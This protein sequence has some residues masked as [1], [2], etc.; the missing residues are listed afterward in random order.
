MQPNE[1]QRH[2]PACH[3][4]GRSSA[5]RCG[6]RSCSRG[7]GHVGH[8]QLH[9]PALV[10][11]HQAGSRTGRDGPATARQDTVPVLYF[12]PR[13]ARWCCPAPRPPSQP[14]RGR[15]VRSGSDPHL[16]TRTRLAPSAAAVLAEQQLQPRLPRGNGRR[17]GRGEPGASQRRAG[18]RRRDPYRRGCAPGRCPRRQ[19]HRGGAD[20]GRS[21]SA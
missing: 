18:G 15:E 3:R 12:D 4:N 2:S 14:R 1:S 7:Q 10:R 20:D 19:G 9:V 13:L 8:L 16:R 11:R 6:F 17:H 5:A 21:P